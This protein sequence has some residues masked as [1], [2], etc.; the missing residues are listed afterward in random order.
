MQ[1]LFRRAAPDSPF[2]FRVTPQ[3]VPPQLAQ[4]SLQAVQ[5]CLSHPEAQTGLATGPWYQV[6]FVWRLE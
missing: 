6:P 1:V 4:A 3:T 5:R 2:E